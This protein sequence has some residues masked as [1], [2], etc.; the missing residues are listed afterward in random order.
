MKAIPAEPTGDATQAAAPIAQRHVYIGEWQDVP[1]Y[2]MDTLNTGQRIN[3][4]AIV[5]SRTTTILLVSGDSATVTGTG[6]LDIDVRKT[7]A[8]LASI[9]A[10]DTQLEAVAS[11]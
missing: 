1:V 11:N 4:P 5:E 10:V 3:G 7:T 6:W 8:K 9:D 2:D